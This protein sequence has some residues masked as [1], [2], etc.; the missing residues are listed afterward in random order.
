MSR[1]AFRRELLRFSIPTFLNSPTHDR[2][3][4]RIYANAF[5]D[6]GFSYNK[7]PGGNSLANKML[8]TAGAGIDVVTF[9]DFVFHID[10]S[11]NQLGEK[12]LFLRLKNSF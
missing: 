8:Y 7:N 3:P 6:I 5:T 10:Y 12:G 4:F 11:F 1:Q 2:V 9:Y